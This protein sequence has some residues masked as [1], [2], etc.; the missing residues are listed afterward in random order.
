MPVSEDLRVTTIP[1][2]TL[3]RIL[4]RLPETM[5]EGRRLVALTA[6]RSRV[7]TLEVNKTCSIGNISNIAKRV[8]HYLHIEGLAVGCELPDEKI[9]NQFGER[10]N[11]FLWSMYDVAPAANDDGGG[12]S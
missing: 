8:N 2:T 11:Q 10:S 9:F 1:D 12:V 3:D 7:P 5:N 6:R 4:N